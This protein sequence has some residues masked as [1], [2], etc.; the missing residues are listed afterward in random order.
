MAHRVYIDRP[1]TETDY[2][3]FAFTEQDGKLVVVTTCFDNILVC[4]AEDDPEG[5]Y[6]YLLTLSREQAQHMMT[7]LQMAL[8]AR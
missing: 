7:A 3:E 6:E 1:S 4:C 8:D 5:A 2:P